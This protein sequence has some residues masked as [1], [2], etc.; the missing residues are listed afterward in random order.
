MTEL[1]EKACSV[2]LEV[3]PPVKGVL[4]TADQIPLMNLVRMFLHANL[5]AGKVPA[6]ALDELLYSAE[7]KIRERISGVQY[8]PH[9]AT[10]AFPEIHESEE[11]LVTVCSNPSCGHVQLK[12]KSGWVLTKLPQQTNTQSFPTHF[13]L[14][15]IPNIK[16][17]K[18]R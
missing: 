7:Q 18:A 4:T 17:R 6:V 14:A 10:R 15:Q 13:P 2:A 3:H 9:C 1:V 5:D 11:A 16:R 8:C 12:P